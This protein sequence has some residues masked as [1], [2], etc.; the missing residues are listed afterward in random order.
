MSSIKQNKIAGKSAEPVAYE[1]NEPPGCDLQVPGPATA[2]GRSANQ[3]P[4]SGDS[5]I[6]DFDI[7]T[8]QVSKMKR[9]TKLQFEAAEFKS[10]GKNLNRTS[11]TAQG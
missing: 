9:I 11:T 4:E 7:T 2:Y 8:E 3:T 6:V 5:K 1:F 10:G